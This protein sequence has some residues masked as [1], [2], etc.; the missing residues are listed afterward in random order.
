M[1][2]MT[3]QEVIK[4]L[5]RVLSLRQ[6]SELRAKYEALAESIEDDMVAEQQRDLFYS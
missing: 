3:L 4:D 2:F 1:D 6:V 5:D